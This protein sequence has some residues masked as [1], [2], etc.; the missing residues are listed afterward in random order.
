MKTMTKRG[1]SLLANPSNKRNRAHDVTALRTRKVGTGLF[2]WKLDRT[3]W[4]AGGGIAETITI[5]AFA[6]EQEAEAAQMDVM[7]AENPKAAPISNLHGAKHGLGKMVAGLT[8]RKRDD[9]TTRADAQSRKAGVKK[10]TP[11]GITRP[12]L[13]G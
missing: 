12:A 9:E 1:P 11:A 2:R 7:N 13:T 4:P 6:T 3:T 8:F 10:G 5:A